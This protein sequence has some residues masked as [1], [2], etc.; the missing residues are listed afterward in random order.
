M[1]GQLDRSLPRRRRSVADIERRSGHGNAKQPARIDLLYRHLAW[2][3]WY[4]RDRKPL[5]G[6]MPPLD[7]SD[8]YGLKEIG[9]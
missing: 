6:P 7:I 8:T 2:F 5:E 1:A 4:V 3:D 9:E